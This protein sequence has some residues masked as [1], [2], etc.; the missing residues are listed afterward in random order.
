MEIFILEDHPMVL[1]GLQSILNRYFP[2]SKIS[3]KEN[4]ADAMLELERNDY[5]LSIIDVNV[6]GVSGLDYIEKAKLTKSRMKH[7]VFTSSAQQADFQRALS[8]GVDGYLLKECMPED[9]V[10]AIQSIQ[11]GRKFLDPVMLN[12]SFGKK[13]TDHLSELTERE[14]EILL[15]IGKGRSNQEIADELFISMHTVK[16][17]ITHIFEKLSFK[18]RSQAIVFCHENKIVE[19]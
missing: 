4:V 2:E 7:L 16:K 17:H 15:C 8:L 14:R 13:S 12:Y 10:Y 19:V 3:S 6:K 18:D 1:C 11:R 9:L 5:D